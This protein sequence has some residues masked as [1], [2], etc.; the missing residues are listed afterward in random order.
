MTKWKKLC[1]FLR[2]MSSIMNSCDIRL[3]LGTNYFV[4]FFS[5]TTTTMKRKEKKNI[6]IMRYEWIS[7]E[8]ETPHNDITILNIQIPNNSKFI[9]IIYKTNFH[10]K[11]THTVPNVLF[12]CC[13]CMKF[14]RSVIRFSLSLSIFRWVTGDKKK[15]KNVHQTNGNEKLKRR[16]RHRSNKL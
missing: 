7:H 5:T 9:R 3:T 12:V 16:T 10:P 4:F 2:C 8:H 11:R 13:L 15:K 6:K 1:F 14:E